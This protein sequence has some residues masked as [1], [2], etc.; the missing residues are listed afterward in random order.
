MRLLAC[1]YHSLVY[2]SA[3]NSSIERND[4]ITHVYCFTGFIEETKQNWITG[5]MIFGNKESLDNALIGP[6]KRPR[7]MTRV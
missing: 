6:P 7:G 5:I 2:V 3:G 4:R 1:M